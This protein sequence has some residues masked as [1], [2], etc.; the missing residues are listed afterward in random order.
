VTVRRVVETFT[1][2]S[3]VLNLHVGGRIIET[4]REHPFYVDGKGWRTAHE[5]QIGDVL[6]GH[7]GL[8]VAVEGVAESGRVET[9][10]NLEVEEHHTY[11]VGSPE[12]GFD[13]WA[14]NATVFHY[15]DAAG[16]KGMNSSRTIKASV[17][18][19]SKHGVKGPVVFVTPHT[20]EEVMK[21]GVSK[22]GLTTEK[23]QYVVKVD[24][25]EQ[26]IKKVRGG[27]GEYIWYV[28]A[29]IPLPPKGPIGFPTC[30]R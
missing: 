6:L 27:R 16:I 13:V 11:F 2:I 9:V 26:A 3:P 29:D 14:H 7:N 21:K 20:P 1:R 23:A 24:L 4:T 10:Y 15:T 8:R 25:P 17:S 5:L 18:G 30:I 12:W 22:Y 28:P 19:Y